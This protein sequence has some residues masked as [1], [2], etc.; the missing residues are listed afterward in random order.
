MYSVTEPGIW[1]TDTRYLHSDDGDDD[2]DDDND[3]FECW[4]G[5]KCGLKC[6]WP[7]LRYY[8]HFQRGW[9]AKN[10]EKP[11]DIRCIGRNSNRVLFE[12]KSERLKLGPP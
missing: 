1:I 5:K 6:S 9:T 11:Q 12:P 8:P 3:D 10:H 7:N 2:E 4:I